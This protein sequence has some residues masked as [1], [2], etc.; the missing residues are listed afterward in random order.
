MGQG[1]SRSEE[2]GY[3]TFVARRTWR[4]P[5][6]ATWRTWR[7]PTM[8][9]CRTWRRPTMATKVEVADFDFRGLAVSEWPEDSRSHQAHPEPGPLAETVCVSLGANRSCGRLNI[10]AFVEVTDLEFRYLGLPDYSEYSALIQAKQELWHI[11]EYS[12]FVKQRCYGRM[13]RATFVEVADFDFRDILAS[14]RPNI[15]NKDI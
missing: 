15:V 11:A 14:A 3:Y 9:T 13:T 2:A 10:A 8:A 7:M 5:T 4:R 6:M 12:R 1:S